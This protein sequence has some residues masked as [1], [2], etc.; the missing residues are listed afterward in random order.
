MTPDDS[1]D[2]IDDWLRPRKNG[3]DSE[4][5]IQPFDI[6]EAGNAAADEIG[7]SGSNRE[8]I[9]KWLEA[10]KTGNDEVLQDFYR[11]NGYI[12]Q[13]TGKP[14]AEADINVDRLH[15]V[16]EDM[17]ALEELLY[18]PDIPET[19]DSYHMEMLFPPE[20]DNNLN[21]IIV[22]VEANELASDVAEFGNAIKH[23]SSF[24]VEAHS[25]KQFSMHITYE[26]CF[27]V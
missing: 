5:E 10:V 1:M 15:E 20:V 25:E 4:S 21:Y 14:L 18:I 23:C 24:T 11:E 22:Y 6:E 26:N 12:F 27:N 13:H 2:F 7:I 19:K 9:R 17:T 16:M 3:N 8:W